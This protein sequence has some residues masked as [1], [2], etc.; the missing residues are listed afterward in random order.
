MLTPILIIPLA[1]NALSFALYGIDKRRARRGAWRISER[2]LIVAALFGTVGALMGM[3]VFRHKTIKPK[4][5][6]GVPLILTVK[7]IVAIVLLVLYLRST[8]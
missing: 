1:T 7:I 6:I 4:F 3:S 2:T 5:S 8:R